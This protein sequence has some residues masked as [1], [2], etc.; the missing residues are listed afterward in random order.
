[1]NAANFVLP[2]D[3]HA[4]RAQFGHLYTDEA[5]DITTLAVLSATADMYI[6]INTM[7]SGTKIYINKTGA[8]TG[9]KYIDGEY[10]T[11]VRAGEYFGADT[12]VNVC[13]LGE[14]PA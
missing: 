7:G 9:G 2:K 5:E 1:M 12:A 10:A 13:P 6:T 8:K 14:I 3:R 11:I 4:E